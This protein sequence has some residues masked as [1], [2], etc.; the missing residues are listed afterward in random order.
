M[1]NILSACVVN[2]PMAQMDMKGVGGNAGA[3]AHS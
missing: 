2:T 3:S 1:N